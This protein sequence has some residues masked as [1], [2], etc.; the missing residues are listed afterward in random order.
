MDNARKL[1]DMAVRCGANAVKFQKRDIASELTK[2]AYD[3]VYDSHNSFGHTYGEHRE[4]LELDE[5]QHKELK[6]YS[7]AQGITYFCTPCD[8]PSVE[9]MERLGVPFYKVA[10]RDLTN[11]PTLDAIAKTGKPV[12]LSTGM[13]S[14][15]DIE[16][17]LEVLGNRPESILILQCTSQYPAELE[18]VNL[19]AMSTLREKFKKITGFSDHTAG[20]IASVTASILGAAV[21]EKHITLS[22]AMKGSDQAGSLEETGLKLMVKYIREAEKSL[23]DG[24]KAVDPVTR[25]AKEKLARSI[26]SKVPI[27]EGTILE[28]AMLCLKSPGTGLKWAE[29]ELLIGKKS[30]QAI[31]PD[32]TLTPEMFE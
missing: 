32:V 4:F 15:E 30:L 28:E 31:P 11:L 29:K 27:P 21:I 20:I 26:T 12:I 3:R 8:I 22:R 25:P 19:R 1:I 7:L 18:K 13:A 17:A 23:G 9:M 5:E 24:V 10:S 6:E 2:E 14:L 16:Q